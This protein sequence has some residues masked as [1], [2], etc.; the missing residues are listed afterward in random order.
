[1]QSA[2]QS[3]LMYLKPYLL[4]FT[5]PAVDRLPL[6]PLVREGSMTKVCPNLDPVR[7]R[8]PYVLGHIAKI[9]C[10]ITPLDTLTDTVKTFHASTVTGP[11]IHFYNFFQF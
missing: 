10:E 7:I 1:M 4:Y 11:K 6:T 9:G 3:K 2:A 8:A 5:D